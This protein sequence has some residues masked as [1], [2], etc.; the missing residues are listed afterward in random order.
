MKPALVILA[1]GASQRLG[2]CKALVELG[3]ISVLTRLLRAGSCLDDGPALVVA[4][5]DLDPI[6]G[7]LPAGCELVHNEV[8][9]NGRST[10]IVR[11]ARRR[12]GRAL[13]LAPVDVPLVPEGVF[14]EL[15]RSWEAAGE[16][17]SGWLAPRLELTG[18][19]RNGR[20]GHPVVVGAGL[21]AAL[22]A[23]PP[24]TPLSRLRSRASPLLE[25]LTPAVEI[26]DDLD[27][28]ADL[29][30]LEKRLAGA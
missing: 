17:S 25:I 20:H 9:P 5:A 7:A 8:W 13:C 11:A 15:C 16:P 18:H 1:A 19:P 30:R 21:L 24:D 28:P 4:G 29:S 23:Q 2:R 14:R 22:E 12:P 27:T 26:L 10:S 6:A 3:G